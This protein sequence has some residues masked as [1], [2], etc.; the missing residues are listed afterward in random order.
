MRSVDSLDYSDI[1]S[2]VQLKLKK[3]ETL[4]VVV[5]TLN[6]EERVADVIGLIKDELVD[7]TGLVDELLVIDG[8]STDKTVEIVES[9]GVR[10]VD[11]R[12]GVGGSNWE[13]GKGLALWRS[14]F[15]TK[16]S[17]IAF[18]DADIE[19]FTSRFIT[20]LF[21][22]FLESSSVGFVK[23]FYSR[24]FVGADGAVTSNGG[25]RVTELLVRPFFSRYYPS[26]AKFIQPLSG[27]YA[28]RRS[29]IGNLQFYTGYG[30]ETSLVLDY[31]RKYNEDTVVQVNFWTRIHRNRCLA[32][33]GRMSSIILQTLTDYLVE[34]G[35]ILDRGDDSYMPV[36]ESGVIIGQQRLPL[37]KGIV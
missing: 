9:L 10:V 1:A 2:L 6:E 15:L 29:V 25:G 21:A 35:Y 37:G 34:D 5:P 36:G 11:S 24:S 4:A 19:D 22:P 16:S 8:G 13:A 7:K 23:G 26:A 3:G 18:V 28:F 20:G 33:L 14:Q 27:E 12:S 31:L 17:V 32:D 30:V